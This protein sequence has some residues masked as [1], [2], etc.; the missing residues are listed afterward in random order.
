MVI[1]L[2]M[3]K[4]QWVKLQKSQYKHTYLRTVFSGAILSPEI[5]FGRQS[6]GEWVRAWAG[7]L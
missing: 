6:A 5:H 3:K 1:C 4:K 7:G 2:N